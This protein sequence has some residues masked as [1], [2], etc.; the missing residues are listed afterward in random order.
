M[1]SY[2]NFKYFVYSS[3]YGET[4]ETLNIYYT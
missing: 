3:I 4:S 2:Y 1:I